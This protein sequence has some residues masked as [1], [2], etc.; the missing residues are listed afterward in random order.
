[1]R[2][3]SVQVLL[4]WEKLKLWGESVMLWREDRGKRDMANTANRNMR[5][6]AYYT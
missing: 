1:M 3:G 4:W 2:I 5:S 6:L